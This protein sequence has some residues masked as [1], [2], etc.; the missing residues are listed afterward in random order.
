MVEDGSIGI[1][2]I[3]KAVENH[4]LKVY[5]QPVVRAMTGKLCSQEALSRWDDPELGFLA[6]YR[7]IP[8]L[9]EHKQIYK[10]DL[11]AIEQVLKDFQT[12]EEAGIQFN[13]GIDQ[14]FSL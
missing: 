13:T 3:D 9:E 2:N 1:N 5:Y 14:P 11:Y 12:K 4:Y 7:F 8:I 10:V 6:P